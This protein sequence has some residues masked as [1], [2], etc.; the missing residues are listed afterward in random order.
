M[1]DF[2]FLHPIEVRYGDLDP[3][4]HVNNAKYVTYFETGRIQYKRHLGT[5]EVGQSFLEIGL[6]MADLQITFHAPIMWGSTVKVGVRTTKLG[7]KS[8]HVEQCIID[9]E[10][11]ALYA[12]G[13][14][15]L[16]TYDYHAGKSIR[17]PD[18][19][20]A[21]ISEFEGL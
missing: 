21:K 4:G 6:I 1:N 20:R 2:R 19:M 13:K 18:E 10:S 14:V 16:V 12:T 15:V 3:Q 5:F 9:S 11:G 8:L 7:N 17:I